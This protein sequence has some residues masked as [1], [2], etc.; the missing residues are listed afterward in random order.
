MIQYY[1]HLSTKADELI[2]DEEGS[3]FADLNAAR[4]EAF[5]AARELIA[6]AVQTGRELTTDSIIIE[7]A[8]GHELDRVRLLAVLPR[9]IRG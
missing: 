6:D 5:M 7:D 3:D 4:E 2:K 8:D 1:F 9:S